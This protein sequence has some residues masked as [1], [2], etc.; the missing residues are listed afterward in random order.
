MR[1]IDQQ[2]DPRGQQHPDSLPLIPY[3]D[4]WVISSHASSRCHV[5][6]LT[7]VLNRV[8]GIC[9]VLLLPVLLIHWQA[10]VLSKA[11]SNCRSTRFL[12]GVCPAFTALWQ[13]LVPHFCRALYHRRGQR[14]WRRHVTE[15]QTPWTSLNLEKE[16]SCMAARQRQEG[17]AEDPKL[18]WKTKRGN[19]V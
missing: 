15:L 17:D 6:L 14:K 19:R 16:A 5:V 7:Q 1:R 12:L 2:H 11:L 10:G 4:V 3:E 8:N 9:K 18:E 13:R